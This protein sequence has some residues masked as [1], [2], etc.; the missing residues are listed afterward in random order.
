MAVSPR[1]PAVCISAFAELR[2]YMFDILVYLFENY[3]E[4][5]AYPDDSTLTRE[6]SAAGF[7][8]NEISQAISWFHGLENLANASYSDSLL[9]SHA[10]RCYTDQ[11]IQRIGTQGVGLLVFLE[12]SGVLDPL[13]REWVMDRVF[14]VE[15]SELTLEQVK[16]IILFVLWNHN[17]PQQFFFIEDLL[18]GDGQPTLH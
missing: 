16:W 3:F 13:Q 6:L 18:F 9:V 5:N 2:N 11:E 14:A 7:D 10:S 4:M 12:S 17:E 15:E 1:C 8:R